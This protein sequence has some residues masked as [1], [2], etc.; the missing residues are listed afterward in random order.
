MKK[1][2]RELFF[3]EQTYE[4]SP[5]AGIAPAGPGITSYRQGVDRPQ[6]LHPDIVARPPQWTLGD[7][8]A[9]AVPAQAC[10]DTRQ[11][12]TR[13]SVPFVRPRTKELSKTQALEE[14]RLEAG[15]EIAREMQGHLDQIDDLADP[16]GGGLIFS[17][18]FCIGTDGFHV[19]GVVSNCSVCDDCDLKLKELECEIE[20]CHVEVRCKDDE[21]K[22]EDDRKDDDDKKE[23]YEDKK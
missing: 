17:E 5:P 19:E 15:D 6:N 16:S 22:K 7:P 20:L 18:E 14:V 3:V 11:G 8:V 12:Q 9:A 2:R 23:K 1:I 4:C 10:A 21:C 13:V